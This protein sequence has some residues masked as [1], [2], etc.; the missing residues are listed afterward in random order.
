MY[1]SPPLPFYYPNHSLLAGLTL[2]IPSSPWSS[3]GITFDHIHNPFLNC[4]FGPLAFWPTFQTLP[5]LISLSPI[6]FSSFPHVPP[7]SLL[8]YLPNFHRYLNVPHLASTL[9][10][11]I[12]KSEDI[13]TTF[14]CLEK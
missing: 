7:Q 1:I 14:I 11:Q 6:V 12:K 13:L 8:S 5:H 3:L 2:L 4:L 10:S 9:I